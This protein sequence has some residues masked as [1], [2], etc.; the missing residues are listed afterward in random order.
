MVGGAH[1]RLT[2][3]DVAAG[4]PPLLS[5][6]PRIPDLGRIPQLEYRGGPRYPQLVRA[7]GP[8]RLS[9]ILKPHAPPVK[10]EAQK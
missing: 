1:P 6:H 9:E 5:S 3:G 8:D 4:R 2:R 10:A 7:A